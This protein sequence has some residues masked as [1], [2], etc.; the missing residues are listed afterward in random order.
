MRLL[1]LGVVRQY[2]SVALR[3]AVQVGNVLL[4]W[5]Q[6]WRRFRLTLFQQFEPVWLPK[7]LRVRRQER[8]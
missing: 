2:R 8:G 1:R 5:R 7:A 4:L 6:N 3:L